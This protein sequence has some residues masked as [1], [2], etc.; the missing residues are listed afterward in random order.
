[1]FVKF[2]F[3]ELLTQLKTKRKQN[4]PSGPARFDPSTKIYI[5][6]IVYYTTTQCFMA[7]Q[8]IFRQLVHQQT[9]TY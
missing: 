3:I 2:Y 9:E 1:M 7:L 4:V 8:P 5:T 6:K